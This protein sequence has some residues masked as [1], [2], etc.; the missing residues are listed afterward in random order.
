MK[1][2]FELDYNEATLLIAIIAQ[3]GATMIEAPTGLKPKVQA[4]GVKITN[5]IERQSPC[6]RTKKLL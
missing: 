2:K 4:L 6:N 5:Q 3:Q 1:I